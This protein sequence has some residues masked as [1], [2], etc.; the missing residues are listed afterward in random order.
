ME[1][2]TLEDR[3][4]AERAIGAVLFNVRNFPE[5]AQVRLLGQDMAPLNEKLTDAVLA[6][7]FRITTPAAEM[8]AEMHAR[9]LHHFEVGQAITTA[10]ELDRQHAD[11]NQMGDDVRAVLVAAIEPIAQPSRS[12]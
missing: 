10:L 11:R 12:E 3:L 6:A 9:E 4:A 2:P 5:K 8:V 7:G 1:I